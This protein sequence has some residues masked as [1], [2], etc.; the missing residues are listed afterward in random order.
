MNKLFILIIILILLLFIYNLKKNIKLRENFYD[1][2]III[3]SKNNDSEY[4]LPK[5]IYSF[6]NNTEEN[7][8]IDSCI[9]NWEKKFSKE[10]KIVFIS[11]ENINKYV[12]EE[13]LKKYWT[14]NISMTRFS[15]FLRIYLLIKNGGVWLDASVII[16]NGQFLDDYYNEMIQN[17]YDGCF[18]EYKK[19]EV[20][21]TQPHIDNWFIIA[22]KNSKILTDLYI[23]FDKAFDMEFL[24]YKKDILIKNGVLITNTLGYSDSTYLLQHAIMQYLLKKNKNKYNII[25]KSTTENMYKIHEF[26]NWNHENIIKF[27]LSNNS[28]ENHIGIKLTRQN[29]EAIKD[30]NEFIK[31]INEF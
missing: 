17:K 31:K 22:P 28:W 13:F 1:D 30:K 12:S 16:I 14:N 23:E 29:R 21:P 10:W 11:K 20:L 6:W 3:N 8:L 5:V 26:F 9:K 27:I 24:N 2:N 15:D 19:F 25:L 7:L 4:I 18:Y